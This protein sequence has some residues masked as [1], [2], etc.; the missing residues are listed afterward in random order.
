MRPVDAA[1]EAIDA[2]NSLDPHQFEGEP[3]ALVEGRLAHEWVGRLTDAPSDALRLAAR[4]H[5]LRRWVVPR[6]DYPDGRSGYLRWRRDQKQRHADELA[7]ILAEA[8]VASDTAE[9]AS[10]IVAKVGLGSDPE[11]QDFEDAVCLTFLHTQLTPTAERLGDERA[12]A[13]IGKTLA[14]MSDDGRARAS[15]TDFDDH[16]AALVTEAIASLSGN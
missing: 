7:T 2:A 15:T 1:I 14:K 16:T 13:V 5:H 10:V 11:V 6:S 12:V 4:A 9:R 8:G 3:L